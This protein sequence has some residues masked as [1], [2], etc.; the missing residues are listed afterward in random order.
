MQTNSLN[1]KRS[2]FV[3]GGETASNGDALGW[4]TP[5]VYNKSTNDYDVLITPQLAVRPDIIAYIAYGT[6]LLSWFVLQYND[7]IN[8][9][10]LVEG[11]TIQLPSPTSILTKLL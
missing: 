2:R 7:I 6:P 5:T 3:S 9:L 10:D 1:N 4:W 11:R 8:P